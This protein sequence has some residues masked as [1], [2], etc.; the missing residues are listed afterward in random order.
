MTPARGEVICSR[1]LWYSESASHRFVQ[2]FEA[3]FRSVGSEV[4]HVDFHQA[5]FL[6]ANYGGLL[7]KFSGECPLTVAVMMWTLISQ[8]FGE[9]TLGNSKAA[10]RAMDVLDIVLAKGKDSEI[11]R[12]NMMVDLLRSAL[13]FKPQREVVIL[14]HRMDRLE[15]NDLVDL[16]NFVQD[17]MDSQRL[18]NVAQT[19]AFFTGTRSYDAEVALKGIVRVYEKTEYDGMRG[20]G[21]RRSDVNVSDRM[22]VVSEIQNDE[23]ETQPHHRQGP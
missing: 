15:S 14:L 22:R 1:W 2:S 21:D 7:A 10:T 20:R 8:T 4:L 9:T 12:G 23:P 5:A 18:P 16:R 11:P 6:V 19:R 13:N 3:H 17:V